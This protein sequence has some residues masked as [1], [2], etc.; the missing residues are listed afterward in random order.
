MTSMLP[1]MAALALLLG[2]GVLALLASPWRRLS[3]AVGTLGA[4]ASC[5]VGAVWSVT[6]LFGSAPEEF[7]FPWNVPFG[8]IALGLDP[9]SAAILIPLFVLSGLTAIYGREYMLEHAGRRLLGAPAL[10]FNVLVASMAVVVT[11]RDGLLFLVAWEVM[12]LS[13][14]LLV[15]FE[16][17][18][19]EVR[20][21]GWI[22]LVAAHI[23]VA[24]LVALFLLINRQTGT[25]A[26]GSF[27]ALREVRPDFAVLLFALGLVGFGVK[28]GI[29]PLHVW[30]P[31]AHAAAP[32][33]V[34][35]LMSAVLIKLG[36]YGILR[37]LGWLAP[38]SWWG[39]VLIVL[40]L[41]SA[42]IG[43]SLALYQRD[44]KRVLAYSSVENV[45]LM[46]LGMGVGYWGVARGNGA[47]AA[48]GFTGAFLHLWN[49]A[50]MKGL[51]FL[52]AGS[53]LHGR[54]T[55]DLERLGG[56]LKAM[57]WTGTAMIVGAMAIAA[58]PPLNGFLSEW[59]LYLGLMHGGLGQHDLGGLLALLAVGA[60]AFIGSL[61]LLAFARLVGI[62]L[63]GQPR[64]SPVAAVHDPGLPMRASM[65]ALAIGCVGIALFP[66]GTV[67]LLAGVVS[68]VSGNVPDVSVAEMD[69]LS[70]L[71]AFNVGLWV[72][73]GSFGVLLFL[74]TRRATREQ[75]WD[76]GYLA[77]TPR[78]QYTASSFS[79]ALSE[80]LLPPPLRARTRVS[81][82]RE[83]FPAPSSFAAE[84]SDPLTRGLYAPFFA[85]WAGR[86]SQLRWMQ[87]G[88][89]QIYVLYILAIVMLGLGW[90]SV[91][92]WIAP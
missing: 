65:L 20:R 63:L 9:L 26:F 40:G 54:G 55:K 3:T 24:C 75:T 17:G 87:Q 43:I 49:H 48:L 28:A 23:G 56:L 82:P 2:S 74:K 36:L 30:L 67:R 69:S 80:H 45:G 5:T 31:E 46:L 79:E 29:V 86:F 91:R 10:F 15:T 76:C 77:A 12:T 73:M 90:L 41:A 78:I 25:L 58:L 83:L 42:L 21:A 44:L 27:H 72:L 71:G 16:H 52:S 4:V 18:E 7:R 38:A 35:A 11:S 39:P 59:L 81:P 6:G 62:G 60:L 92:A 32:S 89:L 68:Q 47:L 51:L 22:Y 66:T 85:R 50:L 64:I 70:A 34:S 88:V 53:V 37:T 8:R 13:S 19:A 14:Y 33:H 61:T 1:M 57:P 84:C